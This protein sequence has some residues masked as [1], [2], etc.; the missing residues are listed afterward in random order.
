MTAIAL[1]ATALMIIMTAIGQTVVGQSVAQK[2]ALRM[3]LGMN[4]TYLDNWWLGS[5]EKNYSDFVKMSEV[6]KRQKMFRDIARAGFRTIRLPM[7]FGAWASLTTPFKWENSQGP[8]TADLFVKWAKENDLNAIIDL[9]HSEYDGSIK[10]SAT[11][12]RLLWLWSEIASR[13]KNTDPERVFF[14]IRNEPHDVNAREWRDQAEEIIR[15]I[16]KIAPD[17]TLIVGFHDWNSRTAMLESKPFQDPNIIYTFHYY[18]PFLFTHQ[19]ATWSSEGLAETRNIPFPA[20][21]DQ[22]LIVPSTAKGKWTGQLFES[23]LEDANAERMFR[24]LNEAKQW[25][26]KHRVPIFVGEFGSYGKYASEDSRC[27]HAEAAYSALGKLRLPSAWWEWDAGFNMLKP[28][29]G[30]LSECMQKAVKIYR[31]SATARN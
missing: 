24:D 22:K 5:K 15:A 1:I 19:G 31:A 30:E 20:I 23:Y 17:H 21:K 10:G 14:E 9:H 12:E 8:E 25:S 7:T 11:T 6:K 26:D 28:G 2:R 4:L 27:R 16:R 3:E 13:Y 29:T 18:H